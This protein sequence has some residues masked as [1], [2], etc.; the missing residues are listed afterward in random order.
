M[1]ATPV[2][3]QCLRRRVA[4]RRKLRS[5]AALFGD[6]AGDE[7]QAARCLTGAMCVCEYI[8]SDQ[9]CLLSPGRFGASIGSHGRC[10]RPRERV[11]DIASAYLTRDAG[12][13]D[14]GPAVAASLPL[15]VLQPVSVSRAMQS[16]PERRA[17]VRRGRGAAAASCAAC[18]AGA[19][20]GS[21]GVA[22]ARRR[23]DAVL[24]A[25]ARCCSR[26]RAGA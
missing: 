18:A 23:G 26:R 24:A 19:E 25:G 13:R 9:G 12:G 3:A 20:R 10:V 17:G 16:P 4:Q 21:L 14:R 15:L 1:K 2:L 22:G 11:S 8:C 7:A 5:F 6:T